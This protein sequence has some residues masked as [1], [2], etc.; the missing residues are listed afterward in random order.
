[1]LFPAT[2]TAT[3]LT[4]L[5]SFQPSFSNT[6]INIDAADLG[7]LPIIEEV[8][9]VISSSSP[10]PPIVVGY[11]Y[12]GTEHISGRDYWKYVNSEGAIRYILIP[13]PVTVE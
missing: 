11:D 6:E 12:V 5:V 10:T 1:M 3:T 4:F 7:N 9:P 8:G 13:D 2:L